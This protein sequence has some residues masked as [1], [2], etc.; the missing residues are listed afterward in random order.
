MKNEAIDEDKEDYRA[1]EQ[2]HERILFLLMILYILDIEHD[3]AQQQKSA[4]RVKKS[5]CNERQ[6][7]KILRCSTFLRQQQESQN[8]EKDEHG[9]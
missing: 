2:F 8:N 4:E 7:R 5:C 9:I 6:E 3:Q 1:H